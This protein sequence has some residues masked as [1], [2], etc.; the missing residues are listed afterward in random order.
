ML[1]DLAA[2]PGVVRVEALD[3]ETTRI[4]TNEGAARDV[5]RM[6]IDAG[7]TAVSTNPPSLEEVYLSVFGGRGLRV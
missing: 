5:L 4:H 2:V 6:L 1:E 7:V 3:A